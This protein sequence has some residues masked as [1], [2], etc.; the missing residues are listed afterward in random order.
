MISTT[1][2]YLVAGMGHCGTQWLAAFLDRPDEGMVCTHEQ[3]FRIQPYSQLKDPWMTA[4]K[5][6][7]AN[8]LDKRADRYVAYIKERQQQIAMVGDSHAWEPFIIPQLSERVRVDR[9]VFM[10]RNGVQNVHSMYYHNAHLIKRGTW[11]Y[12]DY[13]RSFAD[14]IDLGELDDFGLWCAWWGAN[15]ASA[16]MLESVAPL[17]TVR[18]EDLTSEPEALI[19]LTKSLQGLARPT[20]EEAAEHASADLNR[21]IDGRRDPDFLWATW[22]DHQRATFMR[23]CGATMAHFGYEIPDSA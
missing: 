17:Q 18:L 23:V 14:S 2:Y 15:A 22:T 7:R 3:K 12:T 19:G 21:K 5:Y 4:L 16:R 9:I 10:V 11:F 6:E 13:L 1:V 8:G 20:I